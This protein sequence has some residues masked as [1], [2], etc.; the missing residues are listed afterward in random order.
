MHSCRS[1]LFWLIKIH[2]IYAMEVSIYFYQICHIWHNCLSWKPGLTFLPPTNEVAR[3]QCF[4]TCL[5]SVQGGIPACNG[6]GGVCLW[7]SGG[8][9][10]PRQTLPT[11]RWPLKQVGCILL[12][13]ILVIATACTVLVRLYLEQHLCVSFTC[14]ISMNLNSPFIWTTI[15]FQIAC[16]AIVSGNP[17]SKFIKGISCWVAVLGT[18]QE[19]FFCKKWI[20]FRESTSTL[21][22][23]KSEY[24]CAWVV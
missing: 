13:C 15:K 5:W 4:Y 21:I 1:Q 22:R 23:L 7:V 14:R 2:T 12:E 16:C 18:Y 24:K 9:T 8:C 19:I 3:R 20:K 6:Q 10:S 17:F 11:P